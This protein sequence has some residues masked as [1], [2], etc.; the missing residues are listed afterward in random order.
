MRR[1]S[2][3]MVIAALLAWVAPAWGQAEILKVI[4]EDAAGFLIIN[5]PQESNEKLAAVAKR[6]KI[7]LPAN[8]LEKFKELLA[9]E[10]GLDAKRPIGVVGFESKGESEEPSALIF[11]PVT[12]YKG[13]LD[14][15]EHEDAKDGIT[16]IAVKGGK[17]MLAGKRG[18]YAVLT[19]PKDRD[20]LAQA[21]KATKNVT[22]AADLN[23][24]LTENDAA[25]VLTS[26]GIK[27]VG[28]KARQ[29]L[30]QAKQQIANLPPEAQFVGKIFDGMESFVKSVESDVS[31]TGFGVRMDGDGNIHLAMRA[32]FVT[33]SGFAKAGASVQAPAGGPLAGLPAGPFVFAMGGATSGNVMQSLMSFNTEILK[34][35]GNIPEESVKKLESAYAKMMKDMTGMGFVWQ[36]GK[37]NQ[38]LFATMAGVMRTGDANSFLAEY[39]KSIAV[40]NEIF[41]G[42]NLPFVP[43]YEVKKTKV[44]GAEALQMRMDFGGAAGLPEEM[45]K[46]FKTMF[47]PD[48]KMTIT[49]AVRDDKTVVV[50]Y[51]GGE[52]LKEMLK[53][54]GKGIGGDPDVARV[55]KALP[56]GAQWAIYLS[57]KGAT[58]F[59]DRAVR[60]ISPIP[61][62]VPQFVATPPIGVGAKISGERYDVH[63]VVP[64]GVIDNAADFVR[65]VKGLL[66]GGV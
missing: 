53:N 35:A 33:G 8:P 47:G 34:T 27:L 25:V 13:F 4:P 57:P 58:E 59:A 1:T 38:S 48:G 7:D 62:T 63:I 17:P 44:E 16:P 39:E 31:Q 23:S 5:R 22:L 2:L 46:M 56:P 55:T 52:G 19:L 3:S 37:E 32:G 36:V 9:L 15:L 26:R 43:K 29:G 20:V 21:L 65:Q 61:L 64:A 18:D 60:A 54:D 11:V 12:D 40:I 24:W 49:M 10:Q 28:A 14:R 30:D 50:R 66:G 6:L 51:T 41:G 45:Q 42:L